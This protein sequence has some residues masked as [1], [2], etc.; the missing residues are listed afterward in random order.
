[1]STIEIQFATTEILQMLNTA[2]AALGNVEP[3]MKDI[4]EYMLRRTDNHFELE[5][6]PDG[7]R[8]AD[9][10]PQTWARKKTK[11][12]LSEQGTRG[13]LRGS[14][15]YRTTGSSV[16]IGTIKPYAAILQLGGQTRAHLIRPKTKKALAWPGCGH[17]VKEVKHPGS[18]FLPR[19][20]LGIG[21][22]DE[23]EIILII[24][25]FMTVFGK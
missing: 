3:A 25:N 23:Q 11:K 4:G 8:W 12:I 16:T 9:L 24:S 6:D 19:P 20:F 7:K 18:K 13:G 15:N 22:Q 10:H 2:I 17:P 21:G 14:I 5:Q 1:M